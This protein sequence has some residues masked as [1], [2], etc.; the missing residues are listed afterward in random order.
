MALWQLAL[1]LLAQETAPTPTSPAAAPAAGHA[2]PAAA[3]PETF[4]VL[5]DASLGW[6]SHVVLGGEDESG[7]VVTAGLMAAFETGRSR[8]GA[9]LRFLQADLVTHSQYLSAS[10]K[11]YAGALC[12]M[13]QRNGLWAEVCLGARWNGWRDEHESGSETRPDAVLGVGYDLYLVPSVAL[14]GAA[15]VSTAILEWMAFASVGLVVRI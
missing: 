15:E 10:T 9:R 12:G 3:E 14:R 4:H 7:P 8:W 13:G 6:G 2:Q 1:L 5:A 11:M